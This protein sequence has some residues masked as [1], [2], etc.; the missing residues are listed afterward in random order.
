MGILAKNMDALTPMAIKPRSNWCNI[1][2]TL[3]GAS[4]SVQYFLKVSM[5]YRDSCFEFVPVFWVST[6]QKKVKSAI[7]T[8]SILGTHFLCGPPVPIIESWLYSW[9]ILAF[10]AAY[11]SSWYHKMALGQPLASPLLSLH[12]QH[13]GRIILISSV[14]NWKVIINSSDRYAID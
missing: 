9:K 14:R 2:R 11:Y 6:R 5:V 13:Q 12:T 1:T 8:L 7:D 10:I 4:R 3:P